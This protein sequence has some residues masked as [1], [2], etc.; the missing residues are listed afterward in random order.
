MEA[1][2]KITE[3]IRQT[4]TLLGEDV[5]REGLVKTPERIAAFYEE[6][7][8][9]A[10]FGFTCFENDG[11]DEMIVQTDIAFYSLCEHHMLPFFG[12]AAIGY[13][14]NGRIVGLS[15]LARTVDVYSRKL[16]NQERITRQ[17]ADCLQTALDP[18]GIG[19]VLK[20]RHLCME[21]R[22][23]QKRGTI[24]KTSC[25]YGVFR[26][27]SEARAEFMALANNLQV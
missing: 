5:Y 19:V 27:K 23:I 8:N 24:T 25:L 20:A 6:F 9:P 18:L 17:I 12:S 16:Q 21:M 22:G 4:I 13:I 2:L 7:L 11:S 10:K 3:H 1:P 15:K 14:P 26:D